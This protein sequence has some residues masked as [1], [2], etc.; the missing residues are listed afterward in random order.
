[1]KKLLI[2]FFS[3]LAT[4]AT[5]AQS[6]AVTGTVID[7]DNNEPL[8]GVSVL[9]VGTTNG[10]VTDLDGNF[11]LSVKAGATLQLSYVG[12]N[13][14]EVA[15]KSN[16]GTIELKPE[17]VGLQDVTVTGQIAVQRKTPIAVSQVT[18]LEI[19]ERIGGGE[20]VEVLKNTPGVHAN[21]NGGSWGD[22][23]IWMRGF[24]NTNIAMMI[25]GVPMNGMENGK[26]YWSNWQGLSDVTSVM[27]TQRGLGA[28]KMSAPSVGG[29]INIV[30]KGLDAKRGG[31][32]SYS[33]GDNGYNKVA[34][35]VSTGL[36]DNGWAIT[37]MGSRTWGDGYIQ[38]TS[39]EGYN[40]FANISKRINENHQLSLTAFGAPQEHYQRSGKYSA[41]TM[42]EWNNVRKYMKDG[43]HFSRYNPTYGYDDYGNQNSANYNVYHKPQISLNHVW[44]INYK[45]SLSTTAYVSL[46]RGY[47]RTAEPGHGSSYSYSDLTNGA[48]NGKLSYTFRRQD[49]TFDYGAVMELN[50]RNNP[51]YT[52][53]SDEYQGEYAGSQLVICENR[54]DHNWYGLTSTYTN[55]FA[56][57]FDFYAGIDVRYYQGKHNATIS[58][59]LGGEYF[60]D[61]TRAK[62]KGENNAAALDPTWK[63]EKLTIGDIAYRNYDGFV[64]QEGAFAQLEYNQNNWSA[65]VNG[66]I[67]YNH[68]WK[69]DYFYYDA[70]N[71]RSETLGF[72]GGTIK[73]GAN[74]EFNK[75]HNA[76]VNLGYI[77]RAPNLDYGAFMSAST[78]NAI[79]VEA[80]NEQIASAEIGY[81]F[82][83][84]YVNVAVNGYFTEWLDKTMTKSATLNDPAQTEY[85]MNM[86][87]VNARHM[88]IEF[89]AKARPTKWLE[90]SAMLSLG[91]W[92][93]DSDSVIGYIYDKHGLPL[94]MDGELTEEHAP[95][96]GYAIINMKGINVGGSAQTTANLG[97]TF[98]PFKGFRIGAEY[99]LYDRN[100][101][102]YSFSGSDLQLGKTMNLL[103]PWRVPTAGQLDMRASYHFQIGGVDATLAGNIDNVLNQIYIEKAWNPS[104]VS[105]R[106]TEVNADNVYFYFSKGIQYNVRLKIN[107]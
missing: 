6:V 93:W 57:K 26:V 70:E 89:E 4:V 50:D 48:S 28:S 11:T 9:E 60:I 86:T 23:E 67:N 16:L 12:Y 29:T 78:S 51:I 64:V 94:T 71:G 21:S 77:S 101:A 25:N 52:Q 61:A 18:A 7:A 96:H 35:S 79:N 66:S 65:F 46:G 58:D 75:H 38:G 27:Q 82:H 59:L 5:F 19:E 107:F 8:I 92:K 32:F 102:Y 24:D 103:E 63:Y 100:Y 14:Q 74:Y 2:L 84:E 87:G 37:V 76:F 83:N 105:E 30:T 1:M 95:N 69:V 62:V 106:I 45:S 80:K 54:N 17:A 49:G 81:G 53:G 85:Y 33:L 44:Q 31:S 36:M 20:F 56:D 43:M 97:I 13:T 40:Y 98:K 15:A 73:A 68:Y 88:G 3:V 72:L 47:G 91:N 104:T 99:T 39:F 55:K 42:A 90:I 10:V 34:F 41:L 22:S